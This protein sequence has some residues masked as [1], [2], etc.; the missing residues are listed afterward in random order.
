MKKT[1][2]DFFNHKNH[3]YEGLYSSTFLYLSKIIPPNTKAMEFLL[4]LSKNRKSNNMICCN[5]ECKKKI[6]EN[7]ICFFAFDGFFCSNNFRLLAYQHI[8]IYWNNIL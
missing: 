7:Q 1:T 4:E 3:L 2:L 5:P 6:Y 8:S